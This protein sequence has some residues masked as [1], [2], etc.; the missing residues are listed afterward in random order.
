[1]PQ[2]GDGSYCSEKFN[3]F[4]A[5]ALLVSRD[6]N[7]LDFTEAMARFE[8]SIN[9]Y[10]D[11]MME[12]FLVPIVVDGSSFRMP[13]NY[14]DPIFVHG[15]TMSVGE[16]LNNLASSRVK[17]FFNV[18]APVNNKHKTRELFLNKN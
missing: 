2:D 16:Y 12:D 11:S 5:G 17:E 6:L 8:N 4:L 14:D 1:M 9:G 10:I 18:I 3:S 7:C 15:N 13:F